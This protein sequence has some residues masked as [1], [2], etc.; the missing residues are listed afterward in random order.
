MYLSFYARSFGAGPGSRTKLPLGGRTVQE[1]G[2]Y[3]N[4]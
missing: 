2:P 1:A 4:F 3:T